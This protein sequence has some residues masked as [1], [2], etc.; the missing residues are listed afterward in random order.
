MTAV[1]I[2]NLPLLIPASAVAVA[3]SVLTYDGVREV[4]RIVPA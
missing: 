4:A 3:N 2:I 1:L